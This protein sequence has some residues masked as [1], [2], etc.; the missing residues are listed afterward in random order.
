[1]LQLII[2]HLMVVTFR[3][4]LYH[5]LLERGGGVAARSIV[6]SLP[7]TYISCTAIVGAY[8][9]SHL[10]SHVDRFDYLGTILIGSIV[11]E[12]SIRLHRPHCVLKLFCQLA[13]SRPS[14]CLVLFD[15]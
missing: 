10:T 4:A 12:Q 5:E 1:M 14:N 7:T 9:S 11:W 6:P 8:S 2:L 13:V 3:N 15:E